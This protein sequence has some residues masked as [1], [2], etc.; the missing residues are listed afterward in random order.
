MTGTV[1]TRDA[2]PGQVV[3]GVAEVFTIADSGAL[4]IEA[5]I[6]ETYATWI[7]TV[8]SAQLQLI[9][10]T[11]ILPGKVSYVAPLVDPDTGGL[12]IRI[13]MDT[14]RAAP[15]GLTVTANIEMDTKAAGITAPRSAILTDTDQS[16]VFVVVGDEAS[17]RVVTVI[18][19]PAVRLEMTDGLVAGDLL[20]VDPK[21]LTD[22]QTVKIA[23]P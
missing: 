4:V 3:D 7:K 1:M 10:D 15:V 13:S 17:R 2:E 6:D 11:A 14:Q 8:L 12:S 21:G 18:L 16:V 19:W 9:G 22:G 20:I 23:T 5:N